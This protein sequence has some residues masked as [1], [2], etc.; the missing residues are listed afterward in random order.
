MLYL[1]AKNMIPLQ[2][3]LGFCYMISVFVSTYI[4]PDLKPSQPTT[5]LNSK[6]CKGMHCHYNRHVEIS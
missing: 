2:M 4:L 5:F 1:L 3:I 6:Y